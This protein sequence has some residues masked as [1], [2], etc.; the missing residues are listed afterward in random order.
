MF[1]ALKRAL[2]PATPAPAPER[3]EPRLAA[4]VAVRNEG[5]SVSLSDLEG[6]VEMFGLRPA[7]SGAA[8]TA[9]T[10]E[11]VAAVYACVRLI[12][13]AIMTLPLQVFRRTPDDSRERAS[14]HPLWWLLNEQPTPRTSAAMAW[15][16]VMG[17]RL[18]RGDGMFA[19]VTNRADEITEL[20]PL[21]PTMTAVTVRDKRLFYAVTDPDTGKTVG[22]E[23]DYVLHFPGFGWNLKRGAAVIQKGALQATGN[24]LAMDDFS[25]RFFSQGASPSVVLTYPNKLD[26]DQADRLRAMWETRYSG[27]A[28]AHKPLI[29]TQGGDLKQITIDPDKAQLVESRNY[30]IADIARAFGIPPFM[31]GAM[32]KTTAW[33]TGIEQMSIAF[34]QYALM[35][36]LV[37]IQQEIN[38]KCFGTSRYFCEFNVSGL[39]RGDIQTRSKYYREMVGGSQGPGIMTVNEIRRLENLPPKPGGEDL[40]VPTAPA[41]KEKPKDETAPQE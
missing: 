40:Y 4:P 12:A 36:H 29:L 25:G 34:V 8:V 6:M 28:N 9:Q 15:D 14:D 31:I 27:I 10:S 20:I 3:V 32:D 17:T 33:G 39:L 7:A 16:Y 37:V 26:S 11:R 19:I 41:A 5:V 1:E 24:A 38:R 30:T 23:Q 35:P 21:D 13:G 22:L 2:L 18:L